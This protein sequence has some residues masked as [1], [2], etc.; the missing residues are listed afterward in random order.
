MKNAP[1]AF[2]AIMRLAG[3]ALLALAVASL[4]RIL[5]L[6]PLGTRI[7]WVTFYPAV[8]LAA[9]WGGWGAGAAVALGSCLLARY[10]WPLFGNEPFIKV[11]A[12]WLGLWAFLVNCAMIS[13]VAEGMRRARARAEAARLQ[14]EA[15]NRAKSIFLAS[16]SH[17]LRTP[18]NAILGFS[19][20][21][22]TDAAAT[23]EQRRMLAIVSRSGTH[24]LELINTV[25]DMAKVETGRISV[26]ETDFD[27][28]MTLA[29]IV[30]LLRNRAD[31]K[32]L[33]LTLQTPPEIPRFIRTDGGKLRQAVINLVGNAIKFTPCG[34]VALRAQAGTIDRTGRF[35]L[36]IEVEDTGPGIAPQD[37]ERIFEPFVQLGTETNSAGTGLGLAITRQLVELLGG[38]ARVHST[39]GQGARFVLELPVRAITTPEAGG[40][41]APSETVRRLAPGHREIRVLIV[42]DQEENALLLRQILE[43]AGFAI[44]HVPNGAA[45]LDEFQTWRPDFIWMDWR[46]PVMDGL[47]TTRRIRALPGGREVRIAV[48]SASVFKQE[49]DEVIAAGADD[50]VAK[51]L[52]FGEVFAALARLP[53]VRYAE[54]PAAPK[55]TPPPLTPA[56]VATL[57]DTTLEEL[58]TALLSLDAKRIGAVV[59][60]VEAARP[61]IGEVMRLAV[62]H[63][64]YSSLLGMVRAARRLAAAPPPPS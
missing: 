49:R 50:F 7:V 9:V 53:G 54:E 57:P 55:T 22:Q 48:L 35:N 1:A 40:V 43:Q 64:Q 36:T 33:K 58:E 39:P 15:A 11:G 52:R 24:L 23:E 4:V 63:L 28:P 61:D 26:E 21:L 3:I 42:E 2:R 62:S 29:G 6:A 10:G 13:A 18:L 25:L 31:E 12:D 59:V 16:M 46:M 30:E 56:A 47:E 14:A 41:N 44:R 51:P 38:S 37:Q 5:L 8:M 60:R 32:G 17:E 45:A 27:L 19:N 20:L 34:A